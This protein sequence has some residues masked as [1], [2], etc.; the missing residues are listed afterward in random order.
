MQEDE[1]LKISEDEVASILRGVEPPRD[2]GPL[3]P[4]Y[5]INSEEHQRKFCECI[6]RLAPTFKKALEQL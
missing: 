1:S 5:D 3:M 2:G 6:R 4:G